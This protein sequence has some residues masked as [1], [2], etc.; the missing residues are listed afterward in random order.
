DRDKFAHVL[1]VSD[2]FSDYSEI[3]PYTDWAPSGDDV[4]SRVDEI[5][6]AIRT[7]YSEANVLHLVIAPGIGRPYYAAVPIDDL[8][9]NSELLAINPRQLSVMGR[10]LGSDPLGLWKYARTVTKFGR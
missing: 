4:R 10:G 8:G 3:S 2:D 7:H 6:A 9:S 1:T 5:G